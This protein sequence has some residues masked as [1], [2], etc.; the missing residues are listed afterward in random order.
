MQGIDLAKAV[1]Q[2]SS[3]TIP[4]QIN[5]R[6]TY[7]WTRVIESI[8]Q[9]IRHRVNFD[10]SISVNLVGYL[11]TSVARFDLIVLMKWKTFLFLIVKLSNSCLILVKIRSLSNQF[12]S[13]FKDTFQRYFLN[14]YVCISNEYIILFAASNKNRK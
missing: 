7:K 14:T 2:F 9:P 3:K 6:A 4:E 11:R 13:I 1:V 8:V 10:F 12:L 5:N